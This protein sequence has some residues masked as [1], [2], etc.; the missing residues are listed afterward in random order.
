MNFEISITAIVVK[1]GRFLITKRAATK[2]RFPNLWT[3]PGGHLEP[4]D[5]NSV[6]L[7][8]DGCRYNVLEVA[9]KR[10]VEEETGVTVN[11]VRY[12]TN[13]SLDRDKVI[14]VSFVADWEKG[15]V[16][17][18]PEEATEYRWVTLAEAR[19]YPLISG[20]IDELEIAERML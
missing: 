12:C 9:M 14:V 17:L 2:K 16:R 8:S 3:V 1:N 11:N 20:I 15:Q 19:S 7:N 18:D 10:E 4:A 5:F 13:L 6:A